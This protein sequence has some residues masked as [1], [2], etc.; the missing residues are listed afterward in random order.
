MRVDANEVALIVIDMQEKLVPAMFEMHHL[1]HN[2]TKLIRGCASL[3]VPVLFSQQYTKGLGNTIE[4][5]VSAYAETAHITRANVKLAVEDP[6]MPRELAAFSHIEKTT[7]S[8][9]DEPAF[10]K[11]LEETGRRD[12][13]LCGI[14]AHVCVMQSASSLLEAGFTVRIAAD[15]VSSRHQNDARFAYTRME[16]DGAT[17]TTSEALIFELLRDSKHPMF[18]HVSALVK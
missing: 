16:N 12:V 10:V 5:V 14:E 2:T 15:A 3:D 13:I 9:M 6:L 4:P 18:R 1:I 11:A 17:I 7:F 8:V